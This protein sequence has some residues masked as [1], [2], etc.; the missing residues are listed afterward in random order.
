[1]EEPKNSWAGKMRRNIWPNS[2]RFH[3]PS[4]FE[5]E[6]DIEIVDISSK[7]YATFTVSFHFLLILECKTYDGICFFSD[8]KSVHHVLFLY[9]NY[10]SSSHF[11]L[12]SEF[13]TSDSDHMAHM[14]AIAVRIY[15]RYR[16]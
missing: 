3:D 16:R 15:I 1:M 7:A 12:I 13:M 14:H 10:I 11:L 8:N 5:F 2:L 6:S 9:M 4:S